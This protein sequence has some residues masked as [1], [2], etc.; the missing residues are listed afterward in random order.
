M[1]VAAQSY[2]DWECLVINDGSTDNSESIAIEFCRKDSRFKYFSKENSGVSDTRNFGIKRCFGEFVMP[3][4]GDDKIGEDYLKEAILVFDK[5]PNTK[6]VYSNANLFGD[7]NCFWP[8]PTYRYDEF[9]FVNCIFCSAVF[10]KSDFLL[11][12]GYDVEMVSAYEDWEFL[13]RFLS[14]N[15]VVFRLSDVHF[16]YRQ[17]TN[18]R[19]NFVKIKANHIAMTDYI[20]RKHNKKY[21]SLLVGNEDTFDSFERLYRRK[22]ELI[23][24]VKILENNFLL[25]RYKIKWFER[26]FKKI[27]RYKSIKRALII[28]FVSKNST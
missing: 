6:L 5:F 27:I 14:P 22:L 21:L 17:R 9:L 10:R 18:S 7:I 12:D 8:L 19:N 3:L 23:H 2:T 16:Y 24:K 15:D 26:S 4:D 25:L 13:I 1:S 20:Y 28:F 11:T